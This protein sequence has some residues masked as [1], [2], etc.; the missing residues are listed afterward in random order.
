MTQA[1]L[2]DAIADRDNSKMF[3]GFITESILKRILPANGIMKRR[4]FILPK[5]RW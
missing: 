4:K 3:R 2:Y 5:K 1:Q